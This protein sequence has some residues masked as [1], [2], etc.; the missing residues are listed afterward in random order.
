MTEYNDDCQAIITEYLL[1]YC[2][3]DTAKAMLKDVCSL[4]GYTKSMEVEDNI[5]EVG[6][7]AETTIPTV[8]WK[9]IDARREILTAIKE[10]QIDK[11]FILIEKQFPKLIR[12]YTTIN[13]NEKLTE[14]TPLSTLP[15]LHYTLYKLRCQQFIELLRTTDV[16]EAIQFAQ[17]YLRPCSRIY[18]DLTN[19]VTPLIAYED[20]ESNEHTQEL[21][22]QQRRDDL[23]DEV[24]EMLLESQQL[25]SQ[26][27]LEKL[28]RQKSVIQVELDSQTRIECLKNVKEQ[29]NSDKMPM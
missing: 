27:A 10:G 13:R 22:S 29:G 19:S 24:N 9:D 23:A 16:L 14:E 2:Y 18:A 12:I 7:R 25:P 3:K 28:W 4:N 6:S 20:L 11:A 5:D 1:H 15:K 21:L 26:T 17:C 8:D